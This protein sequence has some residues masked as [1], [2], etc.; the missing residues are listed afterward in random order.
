MI[1]RK[2]LDIYVV[3]EGAVAAREQE[4]VVEAAPIGEGADPQDFVD[5]EEAV[6]VIMNLMWV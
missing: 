4:L 3:A 6:I 5:F 2:R 1:D